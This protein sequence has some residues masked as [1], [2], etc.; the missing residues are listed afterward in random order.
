M[1]NVLIIFNNKKRHLLEALWLS[2][3]S[4]A[5][6][7]RSPNVPVQAHNAAFTLQHPLAVLLEDALFLEAASETA[8]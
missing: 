2:C 1:E 5:V 3:V 7:L 4:A 8:L 6:L